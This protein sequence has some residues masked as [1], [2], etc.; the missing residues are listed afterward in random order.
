MM[1]TLGSKQ[2][3][4]ASVIILLPAVHLFNSIAHHEAPSAQGDE[5]DVGGDVARGNF[6]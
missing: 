2:A 5:G 1:K 4:S 6:D 3:D